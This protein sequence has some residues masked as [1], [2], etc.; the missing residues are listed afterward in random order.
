MSNNLES[1]QAKGAPK[2]FPDYT[3][4][5]AEVYLAELDYVKK[6]RDKMDISS[7]AV[8]KECERVRKEL[9]ENSSPKTE[10]I[11]K[12]EKSQTG[13]FG[14][15]DKSKAWFL[16]VLLL[17]ATLGVLCLEINCG[18]KIPTSWHLE[19]LTNWYL[20]ALWMW[21]LLLIAWSLWFLLFLIQ[22]NL[23]TTKII[24]P[25]YS[26]GIKPCTNTGLVGLAF[27]GG[28][29]RSAIFNL[30]LLQSLAKN[31]VLQYSDYLSTVSGGGYI[32]SCLSSLLVGKGDDTKEPKTSTKPE[33][34]PL[35]QQ[36]N[37]GEECK[38]VS[39]L[40]ANKNYLGLNTSVFNLGNLHLLGLNISA[41]LLLNTV[42]LAFM[43]LL[44]CVLYWL[45]PSLY[46]E[47]NQL[48]ISNISRAIWVI[49]AIM[50]LWVVVIRLTHVCGLFGLDCYE[51]RKKADSQITCGTAI[52]IIAVILGAIVFL[53]DFIYTQ[54]WDGII[55]KTDSFFNFRN[56][57]IFLLVASITVVL[58]GHLSL[59]KSSIQTKLLHLVLF[60]ALITV[61]IT[62]PIGLLSVAYKVESHFQMPYL[63]ELTCDSLLPA[64]KS[65]TPEKK[66]NCV[67][68][69][70]P[71][72][73][74]LY[75][76]SD[77]YL[78]EMLEKLQNLK[79]AKSVFTDDF[80][81]EM[82]EKLQMPNAKNIDYFEKVMQPKLIA[83]AT[84]VKNN[85][86]V[87][88]S[89][90]VVMLIISVFLI[91]VGWFTNI[92]SNSLHYFYR[93]RLAKT[94]LIRRSKGEIKPDHCLLLKDLHQLH[95]G[96]YYLVNTTLNVPS[97]ENPSLHKR[98]SDSFI[99]SRLYCGAESTGFRRTET[100][101]H[102][103]T[104]LAT[105]MALSGAAVSPEMGKDTNPV[106]RLIMTLLNYRLHQ[107]LPN[108]KFNK[109]LRVW[110]PS[111]LLKELFGLNTENDVLLNLSDGAYYENLGIYPLLKRRCKLIIAS[112]AAAD[113]NC[114]LMDFANLQRK[115][116]I[117]FGIN[118]DI[119]MSELHPD[120]ETRNA[121]AYFVK[122]TIH[123]PGGET[124]TL[125]YIKTT[126][127]GKEPEDLL[128]YRRNNSSFP[129]QSTA[130]QFFD[131]AQ[132]ESYRK[133]GEL[134]GKELCSK[135][136]D[137]ECEIKEEIEQIFGK[138]QYLCSVDNRK[139]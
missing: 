24:K 102:G 46:D 60:V 11:Q 36:W 66:N 6:R 130:N 109:Q 57:I 94:F 111:Y 128:A 90:A 44:T 4:T 88:Q 56:I 74:R 30:G 47:N 8:G 125:F 87:R 139:G 37:S 103:Q 105:A 26:E 50:T 135:K 83:V 23:E 1:A 123:Y 113:P 63:A 41:K 108:P 118:I 31:K 9:P 75:L 134:V 5:F 28:G 18:L 91:L 124:G 22:C 72:I 16:L 84:N 25:Q 15:L 85:N 45:E 65:A 19:T 3:R 43:I 80:I 112:D 116:R 27:S 68:S 71:K 89:I 7:D 69:L 132:F 21:V 70:Q 32:G 61:L 115:A 52:A 67:K 131:D 114:Q 59:Y 122:G 2:E 12:L 77:G 20:D 96:P 55:G 136:E 13:V 51:S 104:K 40:R 106:L 62:L 49:A 39:Y 110:G 81:R 101:N 127:M 29:I 76:E 14:F 97:S 133:L 119:D 120:K 92:N 138:D 34:F 64:T 93:D 95:N 98:G 126:M 100:Y 79:E 121:K 73:E 99:F 107:W 82:L 78:R 54:T 42:F 129:D 53:F 35:R 117:D 58:G 17:V 137:K 33:E 48:S 10:E 38:E 86:I